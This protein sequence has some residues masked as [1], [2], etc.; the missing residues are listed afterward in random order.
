MVRFNRLGKVLETMKTQKKD[1]PQ[2]VLI[3]AGINDLRSYPAP[4]T[5]KSKLHVMRS[6]GINSWFVACPR[7]FFIMAGCSH[8]ASSLRYSGG[9]AFRAS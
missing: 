6:V 7:I 1:L 3:M 8:L 4:S 2:I 5:G 9:A